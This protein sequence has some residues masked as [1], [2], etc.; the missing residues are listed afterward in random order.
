MILGAR[1]ISFLMSASGLTLLLI[2]SALALWWPA[3]RRT[4]AKAFTVLASIYTI[5]GCYPLAARGAAWLASPFHELRRGDVAPGRTAVVLLGSGSITTVD[6]QDNQFSFPDPIGATRTFEAARVFR[7]LNA[8]WLISSGGEPDPS[9]PDLPSGE[10]MRDTLVRMG[11]PRER[12]IV[13]QESRTT[14]E[15]AIIVQRLLTSLDAEQVVLVTSGMHMRRSLG[16][17]HSA[18][19]QAIPAIARDSG[20]FSSS[21]WRLLP[22]QEGLSLSHLVVHELLGLAYYRLR[23]WQ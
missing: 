13:E 20:H 2:A 6:W 21:A 1:L 23:G 12:I 9:D 15:E 8:D 3:R 16:V 5:L 7:L 22:S 4:A 19:I 11:V 14:R 18:G 10:T 17:F